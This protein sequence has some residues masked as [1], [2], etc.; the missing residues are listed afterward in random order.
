MRFDMLNN[1][2]SEVDFKG[3]CKKLDDKNI[4]YVIEEK[5]KEPGGI[6]IRIRCGKMSISRQ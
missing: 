3:C 2:D 4:K 1:T 5:R 6:L